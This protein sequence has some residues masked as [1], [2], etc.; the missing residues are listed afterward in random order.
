MREL[1]SIGRRARRS[2][3]ETPA[4]RPRRGPRT[5]QRHSP[6][7]LPGRTMPGPPHPKTRTLPNDDD[8]H[9]PP[10]LRAGDRRGPGARRGD[11]RPRARHARRADDG[12]RRDRRSGAG[13]RARAR[14]HA[15]RRSR[16]ADLPAVQARVLGARAPRADDVRP[17]TAARS[18]AATTFAL[19]AGPC[20]VESREQTLDVAATV[21]GGG[22]DAPARRRLQAAHEPVRLQGPR[23][24]RPRD[25]RRGA[26]G[27]RPAGR[28]RAARRRPTPSSSPST[29]TSCRSARGTCR[30][31]RCSRSRASSASRCCSSAG[32]RRTR[33][34]AAAG[35]RLRPQGGQRARDPLRARD[36]HLRDRHALHARPLAPSRG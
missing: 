4:A 2:W 17:S 1:L 31:T 28:H 18:A 23:Q 16:G 19:I 35:R 20:T 33:R 10:G 22:R 26:R 34:G 3:T 36:P 25:P 14:G 13:G 29:P 15:G 7:L 5:Q 21:Q 8:R 6:A 12:D 24:G 30:T 9:V 27:D 11:G 32:S